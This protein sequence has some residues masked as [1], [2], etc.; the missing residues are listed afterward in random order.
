MVRPWQ[1]VRLSAGLVCVCI[2]VIAMASAAGLLPG[3]TI[4]RFVVYFAACAFLGFFAILRLSPPSWA[5]RR[6]S[7]ES[8]TQN[9][10]EWDDALAE[11][12]AESTSRPTSIILSPDATA[13]T[14]FTTLERKHA[15]LRK[16]LRRL[17]V[18]RKVVR[19]QNQEL[20]QLATRDPLTGCFNRRTLFRQFEKLWEASHRFHQPLSCLMVDVDHFKSI[21]DRFGHNAGDEVLKVVSQILQETARKS[22]FVCRYGGEEFCILLPQI[23][24]AAAE[25]AA[26]R[27]REALSAEPVGEIKVTASF[28]VSSWS[29]GAKHPQE[30][31]DQAD[32]AL[33][34]AKRAGRNRVM[35]F[36]LA[37]KELLDGAKEGRKPPEL[38]RAP[39]ST[40]EVAI[41]FQAV[42]GLL[43]ALGYRHAETAEHCR[44]V[45]D[46]CVQAA[47]GL[48][49]Q[50]DAYL[51]EMAALLHDIGKL[52]VPDNV[53]LKAGPLSADEWKTIRTHEGIGVE[54]IR[55][56]FT[57]DELANLVRLQCCWFGGTPHD[58]SLPKGQKIPLAARL[59][60]IANAYDSMTSE[61]PYRKPMSR[62]DAF[63]ELRRGA[64]TQFDPMLTEHFIKSLTDLDPGRSAKPLVPSTVSKQTA[65]KLGVQIEKLALAADVQDL[66]SLGEM[67]HQLR[68]MAQES[69]ITT[70]AEAAGKLEQ[71]AAAN[72]NEMDVM[73]LML[74]LMEMCRH[75]QRALL[76]RADRSKRVRPKTVESIELRL[77][78]TNTP[79]MVSRPAAFRKPVE[80]AQPP[81]G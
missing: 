73:E 36:D 59:L 75:T 37:P 72:S 20:K 33:Y 51:M 60:A 41:P 53:L 18:K 61:H 12:P 48:M 44:R 23:E 13:T 31:M 49:S 8:A 21:N 80:T 39:R 32:K 14:E 67:A 2:G 16:V 24:L 17:R 47:G 76:P 68:T 62:D 40:D 46:L 77:P 66:A 65:L 22:D 29:L 35:R 74:D 58:M 50:K 43:A 9:A 34:A 70:I 63:A 78:E 7:P 69:G 28:G 57:S 6:T 10:I 19:R 64:G 79:L 71:S 15:Q 45:A 26:E 42:S 1:A 3:E 38:V 11:T 27:L 55:A 56:A 25:H 30:M 54:I 81:V 4:S 5:T 52:G